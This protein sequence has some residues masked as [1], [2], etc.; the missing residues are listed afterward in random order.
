M[1]AI[2]AAGIITE[3]LPSVAVVWIIAGVEMEFGLWFT[4]GGLSMARCDS[5]S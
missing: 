4:L 1:G 2:G 5:A 3:P